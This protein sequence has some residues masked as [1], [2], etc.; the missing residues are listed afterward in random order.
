MIEKYEFGYLRLDG[1]DYRRDLI[2]Y[3]EE[4]GGRRRVDPAW[5]RQEGHRLDPNDLK[6]VV[7]AKPELLVIGTGH[8][9][10]LQVPPETLD[11][12]R[13]AGIEVF[14]GRTREA[15]LRYNE[16]RDIRRV[17]AALHLTC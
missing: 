17:V 11:F 2:I 3:P 9:G 1:R 7:S 13:N 15:C 10:R 14:A 6:D 5:W 4:T 16:T 8:D 12:L